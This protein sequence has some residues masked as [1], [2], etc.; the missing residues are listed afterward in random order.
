MYI[1]R[2]EFKKNSYV[3]H[4]KTNNE[5]CE[6]YLPLSEKAI[7]IVE[8]IKELHFDDEFLFKKEGRF[9]LNKC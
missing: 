5:E 6:R 8:R 2:F 7:S 3:D 9:M 4:I 1:H